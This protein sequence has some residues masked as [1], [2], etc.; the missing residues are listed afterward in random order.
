MNEVEKLALENRLRQKDHKDILI[1]LYLKVA[2][3]DEKLDAA[4][5]RTE[6]ITRFLWGNGRWG[7]VTV[8][9]AL[10]AI[11]GIVSVLGLS[12]HLWAWISRGIQVVK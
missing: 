5:G 1:E 8:I 12:E 3:T 10:I 2:G 4:V 9:Y 11:F 6:T 7:F